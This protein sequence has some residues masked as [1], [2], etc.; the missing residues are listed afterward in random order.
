[1]PSHGVEPL[2]L[3]GEVGGGV[4][5][6]ALQR[7]VP[8]E[9]GAFQGLTVLDGEKL[10]DTLFVR[11]SSRAH[12][13]YAK[14]DRTGFIVA[15]CALDNLARGASAEALQALNVSLGWPDALGLPEVGLFP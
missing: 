11:G 14:D 2:N 10:P 7:L 8:T 12:V 13:A 4:P 6:R 1:M 5:Q 3:A 9:F 15:M